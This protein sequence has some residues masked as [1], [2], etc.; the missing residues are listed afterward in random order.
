MKRLHVIGGK[1][2]GKTT[3]FAELIWEC[4][5][6]GLCVGTTKHTYHQHELDAPGNN[7]D[8]HREADAASCWMRSL[9]NAHSDLG[10]V[11]YGSALPNQ[12]SRA[13]CAPCARTVI[14]LSFRASNARNGQP[15]ANRL[16]IGIAA[17]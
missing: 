3:F 16:R 6:Q 14:W 12:Q 1:N 15:A 9:Q 13:W 5:A 17:A 11:L 2:H 10:D 4:H 7:S 8:R